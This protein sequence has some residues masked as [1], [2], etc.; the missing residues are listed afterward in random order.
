MESAPA[1]DELASLEY[2]QRVTHRIGEARL[3][4]IAGTAL[5]GEPTGRYREFINAA[6][7]ADVPV[8]IDSYREHG[9]AALTASPEIVKIN[10]DELAN[11]TG[12]P[13]A[14]S[15]ERID[16]CRALI[17]RYGIV[18]IIVTLG[19][20]GAEGCAADYAWAARPPRIEVVNSVGSGDAFTA[21]VASAVAESIETRRLL[22]SNSSIDLINSLD[23]ETL[24]KA[25]IRGTALGSANCLD[26]KQGRIE[27]QAYEGI[28][29]QIETNKIT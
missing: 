15:A 17:A 10:A 19:P 1:V 9:K 13:T 14:T 18:W 4:V 21:G 23:C 27:K 3:L 5:K 24:K 20:N 2:K 12:R 29:P 26:I 7:T 11:L 28:R 16:A 25:L 8:L 6:H 22:D